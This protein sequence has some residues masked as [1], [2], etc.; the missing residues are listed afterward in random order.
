VLL[1]AGNVAGVSG[2][3]EE[4]RTLFA[5]AAKAAPDSAAGK[6]AAAALAA[7]AGEPE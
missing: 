5:R 4:A 1:Q 2:N 7:N 3:V 6:A